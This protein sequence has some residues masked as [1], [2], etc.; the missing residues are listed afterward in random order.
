[1]DFW[2]GI[3]N[4]SIC[5]F[6]LTLSEICDQH[7]LMYFY[8]QITPCNT[9]IPSKCVKSCGWLLLHQRYEMPF[10]IRWDSCISHFSWKIK[11]NIIYNMWRIKNVYIHAIG[12]V[13]LECPNIVTLPFTFILINII[14]GFISYLTFLHLFSFV[15]LSCFPFLFMKKVFPKECLSSQCS[16]NKMILNLNIQIF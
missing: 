12:S 1:M 11:G 3:I 10:F 4:F 8:S 14:L 2:T 7:I 13:S 6:I 9:F 15:L 16:V 5:F